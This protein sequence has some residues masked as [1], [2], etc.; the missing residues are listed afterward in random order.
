MLNIWYNGFM[1]DF[2]SVDPDSLTM[3]T[4][5]L[6]QILKERGWTA[7][8]MRGT[9]QY[10]FATR[11]DGKLF[12]IAGT[13]PNTTSFISGK[14]AD[15]K[16]A[17]YNLLKEIGVKQAETEIASAASIAY[18]LEKYGTIVVKPLD[19]AHG[20]GIKTGIKT[21]ED[22]MEA[23][24]NAKKFAPSGLVLAQ[25]QLD[26]DGYETRVICINYH[27]VEAL[28]RIP[29]HVTGDG[30]HTVSELIEIENSTIR[31]EAYKSNLAFIDREYAEDYM[32]ETGIKNN[33]PAKGEKVRVVK[34]CDIGRGGT[35]ED[36]TDNFPQEKRA[37]A[38]RIAMT[39]DLPVVGI[40]FFGDYVLEVNASPSLYYPLDGPRASY[41]VEKLVDYLERP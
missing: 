29:A 6:Q 34:M 41:G 18:L 8:F 28:N 19:G 17:T 7:K 37:L 15:D 23:V 32:N 25:Q 36:E 38:D 20:N 35:V 30:E 2:F 9:S 4:K 22:A 3:S 39:L 13:A 5:A 14:I 40:D 1:E 10:V 31:T 24:E 12:K 26:F 21:F 11:P 27:F 16:L 33:V